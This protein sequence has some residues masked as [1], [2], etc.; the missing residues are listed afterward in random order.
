MKILDTETYKTEMFKETVCETTR[1]DFIQ[2]VAWALESWEDGTDDGE[3]RGYVVIEYKDG[4]RFVFDNWGDGIEEGRFKKVNIERA[5]YMD[6]WGTYT[7][8]WESEWTEC[9]W[10]PVGI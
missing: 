7:L 6:V 5:F 9:G 4:S 10:H 2:N 3:E 8:N 1:K